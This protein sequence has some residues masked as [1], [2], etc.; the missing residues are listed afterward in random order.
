MCQEVTGTAVATLAGV[1]GMVFK[2]GDRFYIRG[3]PL[4]QDGTT[5]KLGTARKEGFALRPFLLLDPFVES[6]DRKNH[7]LLEPDE[8][9]DAYDV[10]RLGL[11]PKTGEISWDPGVSLGTF[12]L[13]VS[14]AALHAS[15]KVVV[16]NTNSGRIG[17]LQ[18]A[19]TPRPQ[20][21]TYAAGPGRRVGLLES[22]VAVAITNPGVVLVLEAGTAQIAAFDLNGNPVRY[23]NAQAGG[24]LEFR[25]SLVSAG[26]PLDMAVDGSDQIY[27]L[28]V[29]GVGDAPEDYRIDVYAKHGEL[30]N[31]ASSSTNI[32]R[33]AID[34]WRSIF[35]A[36]YDPLTELGTS[37]K[38]ID[39][40]LGVA[41][42]S[43]SR[44]DP[45]RLTG[46]SQCV[47]STYERLEAAD[48]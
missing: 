16:V 26:R 40:R 5:I 45:D 2:E 11:D 36:N 12:T 28:Y 24:E 13:P 29:T 43:L 38:H 1:A 19:D 9:T 3:V 21:A 35:G 27:V 37:T 32:P 14:A 20:L 7:I 47:G 18:P 30:F 8:E 34:Y 17:W 25:R 42:P 6:N 4:A 46:Q 31:R 39:P 48:R 23:F 22:P 33:L 41:E 10:R 15:G 44:F